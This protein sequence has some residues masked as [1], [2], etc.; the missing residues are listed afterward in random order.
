MTHQELFDTVNALQRFSLLFVG[1]IA[2]E[3]LLRLGM[4]WDN[5]NNE[6]GADRICWLLVL[7]IPLFG[8]LA[9]ICIALAQ[10]DHKAER[11]ELKEPSPE[12]LAWAHRVL[13]REGIKP[14]R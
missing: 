13:D 11:S 3:L 2:L 7:A 5:L 14:K 9:Y 4:I 8:P 10:R 1:L 12:S 6:R